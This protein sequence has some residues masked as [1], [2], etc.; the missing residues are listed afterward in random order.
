MDTNKFYT[1]TID[2]S[3]YETK[4]TKKFAARKNFVMKDP[5]K[6]YS[7]IPGTILDVYVSAGNYVKTGQPLLILEAMKMK[8]SV[9]AHKSGK[10]KAVYV[11]VGAKI[12][13]NHLMIEF[14]AD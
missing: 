6:I 13:K 3:D 14:E 10:I 2:E 1:L 12:P 8:N 7:I 9:A 5:N 11:A 4:V